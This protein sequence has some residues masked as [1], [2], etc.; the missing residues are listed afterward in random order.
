V[1]RT[2]K[3]RSVIL[4]MKRRRAGE[5][6][7]RLRHR[8]VAPEAEPLTDS[9]RA[10]AEA[11]SP[12]LRTA[13]PELP[14]ELSDRA[15]DG[16]EPLLAIADLAGDE[17]ATEARRAAV[18]LSAPGDEDELALGP[19]LLAGIRRA[20]DGRQA[21]ST[22]DLLASVNADEELPFGAWNEG[23]GIEA[24]RLARLLKPYG[25][26]PK[27][28]RMGDGTPKGYAL[29]DLHDAFARY[30]PGPQQAQQ[31]QRAEPPPPHRTG[32]VADVADA[33]LAGDSEG[34]LL[35][36]DADEELARIRAKFGEDTA[37]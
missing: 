29:E 5:E 27:S 2:I 17:W 32:D 8:N 23:R 25:I 21:I 34:M 37:A 20:M 9:L 7:E 11:T 1:C 18:I 4:H 31:A 33:A 36:F 22:A 14:D 16:W 19:L 28:V 13:N 26:K 24:R 10:W 35:P 3:D 30:L 15:A 6:V 12:S